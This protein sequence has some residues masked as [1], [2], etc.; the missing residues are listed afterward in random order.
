MSTF[1][2]WVVSILLV[3]VLPAIAFIGSLIVRRAVGAEVLAAHN[4]VAGFI[5]AVIGVVYAVLLGFTAIIVWEQ[6]R[7]AQEV[8]ELEANA[9]VD[10]YRNAAVFPANVRQEIDT[11]LRD[12]AGLVVEDEWPKMSSGQTSPKTWDAYNQLWH[13]Y[14]VFE[15][16]NDHQ[17]T[18]YQESIQQL[19]EL[20]DQ[21]RARLLNV[22]ESVPT[23]MWVV[24]LGA[25]AVTIAFSFLFGTKNPRAQGLM[26]AALTLTI[27]VVLLSIL[28][29]EHPYAGITRVSPEAFLQAQQIMDA[30]LPWR[31]NAP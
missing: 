24:L 29:L 11:R 19:N 8:V 9:I 18:W 20:G 22:R 30:P 23:V 31:T 13:T 3:A 14:H 7:R 10:L 2:T 27:G 1:E 17:Q 15:P 25:G 16:R 5:Y 21:R 26:S 4:D 28:A 12:Y 6:F